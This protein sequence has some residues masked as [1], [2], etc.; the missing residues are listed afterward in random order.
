MVH[1]MAHG[2]FVVVVMAGH[3]WIMFALRW[4]T[5]TRRMRAQGLIVGRLTTQR[6]TVRSERTTRRL[7]IWSLVA[8]KCAMVTVCGRDTRMRRRMMRHR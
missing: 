7:N 5:A 2:T 6:G 8:L 4:S 1:V 3:R